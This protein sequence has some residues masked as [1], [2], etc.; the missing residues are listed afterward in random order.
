MIAS[1]LLSLQVNAQIAFF[2]DGDLRKLVVGLLET[3]VQLS[4]FPAGLRVLAGDASQV[5]AGFGV[6]VLGGD[7]SL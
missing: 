3:S 2:P 1:R 7:V 5:D 6:V 4:Q